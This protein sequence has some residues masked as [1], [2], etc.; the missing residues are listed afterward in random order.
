MIEINQVLQIVDAITTIES[1]TM[2]NVN[3]NQLKNIP[4]GSIVGE[5]R[6]HSTS[7][8]QP[9]VEISIPVNSSTTSTNPL[10]YA[11][12]LR[13]SL[14]GRDPLKYH[15]FFQLLTRNR[16]KYKG[17]VVQKERKRNSTDIEVI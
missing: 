15:L 12:I 10:S 3:F 17:W 2:T 11:D 7:T 6:N 8:R 4:F 16:N 14:I 1:T 9:L 13:K 5:F